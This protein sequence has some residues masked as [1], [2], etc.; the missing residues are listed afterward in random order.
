MSI[1]QYCLEP[2]CSFVAVWEGGSADED[3]SYLH[4]FVTDDHTVRSGANEEHERNYHLQ[5][6]GEKDITS[7][8]V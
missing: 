7:N 6:S 8:N 3:P 5:K 2:G 1:Y 4:L